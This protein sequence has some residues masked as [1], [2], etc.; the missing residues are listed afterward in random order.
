MITYG[1][2]R[3]RPGPFILKRYLSLERAARAGRVVPGADRR[4]RARLRA[5]R[6]R[7]RQDARPH[8]VPGTALE[9]QDL[10]VRAGA[11]RLR[12]ARRPPLPEPLRDLAREIAAAAGMTL[13]AGPVHPQ[14]LRPRGPHGPASGQGRKRRRSPPAC[15]SSRSRSATPRDSCSAGC[16][17]AIRSRRCCSSRATRLSSAVRPG[18][19]TTACRGSSPATAPPELGLTGRFNLTFRQY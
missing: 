11:Q 16:A 1:V 12:S 10:P 17:G 3:W 13:D 4:R 19:A 18:S 14:L 5:G 9:R 2:W 6:P 7:R 8:A 15:R